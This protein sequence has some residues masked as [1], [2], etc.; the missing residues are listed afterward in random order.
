MSDWQRIK[1]AKEDQCSSRLACEMIT[2]E[3]THEKITCEAHD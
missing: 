1:L 3:A 2:N